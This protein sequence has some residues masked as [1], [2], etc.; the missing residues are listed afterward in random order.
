MRAMIRWGILGCGNV[1]EVK[2]GPALQNAD[3]SSVVACMR[4]D[5]KKAQD[6]ARMMR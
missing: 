3:R 1:T 4:R 5:E 6:Y 2:S